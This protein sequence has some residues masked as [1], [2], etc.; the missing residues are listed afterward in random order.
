V[1]E[2]QG[3]RRSLGGRGAGTLM[4]KPGRSFP[5]LVSVVAAE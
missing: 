2:E 3:R 4:A 5:S 1:G